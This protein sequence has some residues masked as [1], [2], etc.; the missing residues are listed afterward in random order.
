[1]PWRPGNAAA[2]A[3]TLGARR[4]EAACVQFQGWAL[5]NRAASTS[6]ILTHGMARDLQRYSPLDMVT[7]ENVTRLQPVWAFCLAG[8]SSG[9]RKPSRWCMTGSRTSPDPDVAGAGGCRPAC[10]RR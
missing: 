4:V 8:K 6:D 1:M 10:A 2:L 3:E 5:H 9:V 7:M